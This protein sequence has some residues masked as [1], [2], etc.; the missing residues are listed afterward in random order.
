MRLALILLAVALPMAGQTVQMP[1]RPHSVNTLWHGIG[2]PASSIGNGG[3]FYIDIQ[4]WVIYGPKSN[5]T[6]PS[7]F[8]LGGVAGSGS[9][10]GAQG[11]AG[12]AATIAVGTV[13]ALAAGTTPTVAN[14]G[15]PSAAIFNFGI[16][17]GAT[18]AQGPAGPQGP[19]GAVTSTGTS[20]TS[21]A[22]AETPGGTKNGTNTS[23]T[24]ANS[25]NPAASLLLMRNGQVLA[26][27]QDYNLSGS[28][29]S[30]INGVIP[31][32]TDVLQAW[33]R[34]T[35]TVTT[36][37]Y[38]DAETPSGSVNGVN[39][40]FTLAHAPAGS[41]LILVRNGLVQRSGFDFSLTGATVTFVGGYA[42]SSGDILEAW[43]RY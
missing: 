21:Y 20:A 15:T 14:G 25:P 29:V 28:A 27:G 32:S 12:L 41:S 43:Y 24:L 37:N 31:S 34:F 35:G 2:A 8:A 10:T 16:P 1:V 9:G 26:A 42:P 23:F 13:A 22:D 19:A 17:V 40:V 30:F 3:D 4:A 7:G 18:G 11:P 33:Y 6:W 36:F 39:L 38:S 5:G